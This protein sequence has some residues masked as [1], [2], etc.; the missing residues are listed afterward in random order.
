MENYNFAGVLLDAE[1]LH[2]LGPDPLSPTSPAVQNTYRPTKPGWQPAFSFGTET[3][4]K[5]VQQATMQPLPRQHGSISE[6]QPNWNF[7]SFHG[8]TPLTGV[9]T[10]QPLTER[11]ASAPPPMEILPVQLPSSML[12]EDMNRR[13]G[14]SVDSP[15]M[16]PF[17]LATFPH[18]A[19]SPPRTSRPSY[20]SSPVYLGKGPARLGQSSIAAR[21][22]TVG[23]SP[24]DLAKP[25][26]QSS[27]LSQS[28]SLDYTSLPPKSAPIPASIPSSPTRRKGNRRSMAPMFINFTTKDAKKLLSGVAP[29][30]SSKRK[31]E[32][33]EARNQAKHVKFDETIKE[34]SEESIEGF[35]TD[36]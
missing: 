25:S 14:S 13:R 18:P 32:E 9:A 17:Q 3:T 7:A 36:A 15:S 1:D 31:R 23:P 2:L 34:D 22:A 21:R 16:L 5:A 10:S 11:A 8:F 12:G 29:S 19:L 26:T 20:Q 6:V 28:A 33:E 30:G 4:P 27:P 24:L 35:P